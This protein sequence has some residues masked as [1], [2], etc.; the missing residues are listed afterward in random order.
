M[1]GPWAVY[2]DLSWVDSRESV[3]ALLW[4]VRRD[5][6]RGYLDGW[7]VVSSVADLAVLTVFW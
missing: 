5:T 7:R 4:A 1:V 2:L 3:W 6:W